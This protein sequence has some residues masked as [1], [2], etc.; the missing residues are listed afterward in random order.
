MPLILSPV[1]APL[2]PT[3]IHPSPSSPSPSPPLCCFHLHVLLVHLCRLL[4]LR[5]LPLLPRKRCLHPP[6]QV[7]QLEGDRLHAANHGIHGGRVF[8][9]GWGWGVGMEVGWMGLGISWGFWGFLW[10]LL[11]FLRIFEIFLEV[12]VILIL[13][14]GF[15]EE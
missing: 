3:N 10:G 8:L 13:D 7:S 4:P 11:G 15:G 9:G 6:C 1:Q 14:W 12:F 2:P 5:L